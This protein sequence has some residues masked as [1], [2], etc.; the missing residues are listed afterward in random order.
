MPDK[1]A[2]R[3]NGSGSIMW[4]A[5]RQRWFATM[6]GPDGKHVRKTVPPE[7]AGTDSKRNRDKALTWM[8]AAKAEIWKPAPPPPSRTMAEQLDRYLAHIALLGRRRRTIATMRSITR[9]ALV[10]GIGHIPVNRLRSAHLRALFAQL[11]TPALE[12]KVRPALSPSYASLCL[13]AISGA[14]KL[15]IDEGLVAENVAA[16]IKLP[17]LRPRDPPIVGEH[18]AIDAFLDA[19]AG[20]P[21]ASAYVVALAC[22]LRNHELRALRWVDV[23][24]EHGDLY[25]SGGTQPALTGPGE[26]RGET[27][28]ASGRRRVAFGAFVAAAL[29]HQRTAV[30]ALR[31]AAG[32]AWRDQ[33]LVWPAAG[34]GVLGTKVLRTQLRR[35]LAAAGL[36]DLR[37]HDLKHAFVSNSLA[38]DVDLPTVSRA[39][40]HR[41]VGITAGTYSHATRRG[42]RKVAA[43]AEKLFL[44]AETEQGA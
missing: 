41:N 17:A 39:A 32:A 10:P 37:V 13:V 21:Y 43:A 44:G 36:P 34:G 40:G 12:P 20:S 2:K 1:P 7:V 16:G 27:K 4:S 31:A 29:G 11:L 35:L 3:A 24:V 38:S 33:D 42:D 15:A 25:V 18:I 6:V 14:L 23:D 9:S 28:S 26:I 19:I 8:L 5:A 22:G 30:A